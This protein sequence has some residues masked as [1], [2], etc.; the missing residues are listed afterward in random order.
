MIGNIKLIGWE[1]N[2][3]LCC[4]QNKLLVVLSNYP[5]TFLIH[6]S[7][8][9]PISLAEGFYNVTKPVQYSN[10]KEDI[11]YSWLSHSFVEIDRLN[12]IHNISLT[13]NAEIKITFSQLHYSL[14]T[15]LEPQI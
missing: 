11:N 12:F 4:K 9:K 6:Y 8:Y 7:L 14:L 5:K 13:N 3:Y 2:H 10:F 15:T 1:F